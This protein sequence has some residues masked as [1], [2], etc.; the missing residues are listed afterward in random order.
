[1]ESIIKDALSGG[2]LRDEVAIDLIKRTQVNFKSHLDEPIKLV[3][4]YQARA[5]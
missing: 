5:T 3:T 4:A 2:V 1:M